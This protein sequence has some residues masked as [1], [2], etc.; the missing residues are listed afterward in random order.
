MRRVYKNL[1]PTMISA[2][3][4]AANMWKSSL[5]N[6]KSENNKILYET[7]LDIF[8]SKT[9]L[10]FWM[11]LVLENT[12]VPP[13]SVTSCCDILTMEMKYKPSTTTEA[14]N[15][16]DTKFTCDSW[17]VLP[18]YSNTTFLAYWEYAS[19][20]I[21][22][23]LCCYLLVWL[24]Y[25]KFCT[26]DIVQQILLCFSL[27]HERLLFCQ[28]LTNISWILSEVCLAGVLTCSV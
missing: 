18:C 7:L 15:K 11:S 21:L 14:G 6:V 22:W 5:K 1:Y 9:V 20:Y 10:T 4:M 19:L 3:I 26:T 25:N 28:N 23:S 2:S 27:F 16:A 8:H 24:A 17:F 13:V 12:E